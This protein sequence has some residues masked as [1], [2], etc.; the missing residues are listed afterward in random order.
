MTTIMMT[1]L[2][3]FIQTTLGAPETD[4]P[5]N[6]F[7]AESGIRQELAR[8]VSG[9]RLYYIKIGKCAGVS[10]QT[11]GSTLVYS[12]CDEKSH[13]QQWECSNNTLL[14][15]KG[16]T[17]YLHVNDNN[18]LA[19]SRDMGPRSRWIISGTTDGPCSRTHRGTGL[20]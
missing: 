14:T 18:G 4:G 17:L 6:L 19:L 5:F 10:G 12:D 16:Q 13:L 8:W 1:V 15:L 3:L 9:G 7:N 11:D 2:M 20:E